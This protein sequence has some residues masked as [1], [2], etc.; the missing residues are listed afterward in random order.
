[1]SAFPFTFKHC[2]RDIP[3]GA[4]VFLVAIPL[5]LGIALASGAPP[6]SGL[7]A[8]IVGGVV[9]SLFSGSALSVSGPAAG[10]TVIVLGAIS[11]IGFEKLMIATA[12]AGVIQVVCG[13]LRLG[14]IGSYVPNAVI[15]GMLA[16]IGLILIMNQLPTAFGLDADAALDL[17]APAQWLSAMAPLAILI[18]GVSLAI[19]WFWEQPASHV[20]GP[21]RRIPAP[22]LAVLVALAL[23]HLGPMMGLGALS[24][25]Q[26]VSLPGLEGPA[27]FLS[28]IALP[29]PSALLDPAVLITALT[30]ALI[31][32]LETL[33]SIEAVDKID[34]LARHSP[35]NQEL[36]AQ[37]VG[38]FVCGLIGALPIT[39][40]IVRSSAN[41]Q[42]GGRTRLAS[43][44]HGGLLLIS[45]MFLAFAL[46]WIP[47]ACLAA[48]L[49]HTGFKLAKP[50]MVAS[51]YRAGW[52][53]FI[54]FIVT[55]G[56]VVMTDLIKGV[57]AG[58]ICGLFFL[59]KSSHRSTISFTKSGKECV[60]KIHQ[61][62]SFIN[63][64]RMRQYLDLV[65]E[66]S[67][68]V[69]DARNASFIDPDIQEDMDAF[70]AGAEK[71][72]ITVELQSFDGV[73]ATF[74]PQTLRLQHAA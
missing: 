46:E 34:P 20:L 70:I 64:A 5:C 3:A 68:L 10:L 73:T 56:T 66:G 71:R 43:F 59:L 16:A 14:K 67:H 18:A 57:A 22:L 49:I 8:G 23:D 38:N 58:V 30:I 24:A 54:P 41:V 25:N 28:Q 60:L 62:I 53:R 6:I 21:F 26:H 72:D 27:S 32:S 52:N 48:I 19:L 69:I 4:V 55:V 37:G 35:P 36:K 13:Y 65:P 44:I 2:A 9:V 11:T 15:K 1:M 31:A 51:L 12:L 61:D 29:D 63:R 33:L 74:S 7:L 45:A 47:L 40:V 50:G 39:A 42:A 17:S